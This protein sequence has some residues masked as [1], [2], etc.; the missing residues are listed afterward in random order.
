MSDRNRY[1]FTIDGELSDRAIAAF[2]DLTAT[3]IQR[4][5]TALYGPVGDS[6]AMHGILARIDNL[7]FTLVEMHRLPD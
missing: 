3:I 5:T 1:Q 2:P 4:G 6:T 7:G